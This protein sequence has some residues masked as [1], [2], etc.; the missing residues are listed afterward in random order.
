MNLRLTV[1]DRRSKACHASAGF[2]LIEILVA[3]AIMGLMLAGVTQILASVRTT[4]DLVHNIQETQLAGPAILD[5]VE[6]DLRGIFTTS[7]PTE[8]HLQVKNEV[9]LGEDADRIDFFTTTDSLIWSGEG[10]RFVR[11]DF[12]EVGYCLRPSPL[13]DDFLEIYRREGFGIDDEPMQGGRY[14]FLHDRVVSFDIQIYAE[15]GPDAEP[16]EEWGLDPSDPETQGLP[17]SI[18]IIL[19][20]EL[21]PRL[22]AEQ[23]A[24]LRLKQKRSYERIIRFPEALRVV[25]GDVP[26]LGIPSAEAAADGA[27]PAGGPGGG[28]TGDPDS[29]DGP[30]G[31]GAGDIDGE[32]IDGERAPPG[33]GSGGG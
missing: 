11:A 4:R 8:F 18:H 16:V 13:N 5:L 19:Q 6:R 7:L 2:T 9:I 12:N 1:A 17:A 29:P 30:D 20:I 25:E 31:P 23:L 14:T 26:R 22:T 10:E 33:E 21:A 3:V 32:T 24:H 28:G 15:D 27:T